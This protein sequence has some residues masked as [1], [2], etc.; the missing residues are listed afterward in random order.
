MRPVLGKFFLLLILPVSA[1][2]PA[3]A[4]DDVGHKITAYVAWQR[5]SPSARENVIKIL[6]AAPEDS[7]LAAFYKSYG[8]EPEET[9]KREYF[10]LVATW[11]DIVRDREF[12]TRF[13]KYH[14]GNWHYSDT[15]WKQVNGKVEELSGF[16][17]GG[18]G[19]EKLVE[20]DK[21]IRD[22]S[23]S[24][25]DKAIAIAWIMHIGGDLHQPLHTSARVTDTEPKGD[26][27]GNL[28]LLSPQGVKRADQVNLHW[29]WDSI[30]GRNIPLK[31]EQCERDYIEPI[32]QHIMKKFPFAKMQS[33][34][35]L[36]QYDAWQ[37]EGFAL[38]PTAVFSAD[39]IRNELPSEKYRK[40][41]FEVAERQFAM[42]GYRL[43][44]TLNGIFGA[45][46]VTPVASIASCQI[47]RKI[48]Y[49]VF[50]KQTPENT[51]KAKP[52]IA[53]LN[54]CPTGP[55][56]RPTTMVEAEGKKTAR[57]FDVAKIFASEEEARK[58][59]AGN[60]ITD[61]KFEIQ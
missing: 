5:M 52:T 33:Q 12:K 45:P 46:A 26:Q 37:K 28:F 50:K 25:G 49:P 10:M 59:A 7:Q 60:A 61:V 53:A 17:E 19:V 1:T 22:P 16:P 51:A 43:G 34:L 9:R 30:T 41:A 48:M 36:G 14:K 32:A 57:A 24:N 47:I 54:I 58:Y 18:L 13:A 21:V 31:G 11:A 27:G 15:F 23:A 35:H 4:W 20:L 29:F 2:L 3:M 55:A 56:A 6:R 8:A 39:L 38:N 40:N 44:E 42:A